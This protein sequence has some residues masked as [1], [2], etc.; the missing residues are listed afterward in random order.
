MY[1]F[2]IRSPRFVHLK[3]FLSFSF[4]HLKSDASQIVPDLAISINTRSL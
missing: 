1:M 2:M 4:L 3:L